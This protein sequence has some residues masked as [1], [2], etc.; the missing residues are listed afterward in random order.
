MNDTTV[1]PPSVGKIDPDRVKCER[2]G[3]VGPIEERAQVLLSY[4]GKPLGDQYLCRKCF[5]RMLAPTGRARSSSGDR[6][7]RSNFEKGSES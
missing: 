4:R 2:C 7:A 1:V 6:S 5:G 3:D